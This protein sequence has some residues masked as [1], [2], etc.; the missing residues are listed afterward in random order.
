MPY[1]IIGND[2]H[3]R[4]KYT[5]YGRAATLEAIPIVLN[6][7]KA[8]MLLEGDDDTYLPLLNSVTRVVTVKTIGEI[9]KLRRI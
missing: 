2:I 8:D 9:K 1:Y 6:S 7:E 5:G 4:I 3:G